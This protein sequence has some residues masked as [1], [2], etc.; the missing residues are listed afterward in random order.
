MPWWDRIDQHDLIFRIV[1]MLSQ[2]ARHMMWTSAPKAWSAHL[3]CSFVLLYLFCHRDESRTFILSLSEKWTLPEC[4]AFCRASFAGISA[5]RHLPSA[6]NRQNKNSTKHAICLLSWK[7][8]TWWTG[9]TR[10]R[11]RFAE[12]HLKTLSKDQKISRHGAMDGVVFD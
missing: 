6:H 5:K 8:N 2:L 10:R 11:R 9:K 1:G 3:F 4:S 12:C 7:K